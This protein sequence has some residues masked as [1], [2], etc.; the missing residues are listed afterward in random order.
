MF[1][2]V[3][4][5]QYNEEVYRRLEL[6]PAAKKTYTIVKICYLMLMFSHYFGCWFQL[7]DQAT[8]DAETYGPIDAKNLRIF[9][10]L[11]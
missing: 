9:F 1:R 5:I 4:C 11:K 8:M 6:Y 3:D 7:M 2:F 10:N